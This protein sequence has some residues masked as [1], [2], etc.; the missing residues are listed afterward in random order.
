MMA[1]VLPVQAAHVNLPMVLPFVV[2]TV[3]QT[4][5]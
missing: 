5:K 3:A 2:V 1:I 4:D